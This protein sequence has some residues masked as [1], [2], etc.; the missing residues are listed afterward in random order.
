MT[1]I[2]T[3][4]V[5]RL[6][7]L[8]AARFLAFC[9]MVLVNFR[10]AAAVAPGTDWASV[11]IDSLE[12]R[13]AALFV[14][15][16]GIG[17]TLG[18]PTPGLMIRR[19]AFLFVIGVVNMTIF[20]ADILHFYALYFLVAVPFL[21]SGSRTLWIGAIGVVAASVLVH[22]VI[23]YDTGWDWD[24][25]IYTDLWTVPGFL[26]N[27]IFNGWHPVLP[28]AAFLLIGMALGR[29]DL[30]A[31][32]T[33]HRLILWGLAAALFALVPQFLTQDPDLQALLGTESIPPGPFYIMAGTGTACAII[34]L[35]LKLMPALDRLRVSPVLT[36]P[37][38]QTLT[39]YVAHILIGMGTLEELGLL[40]GSLTAPQITWI[41][42]G[43]AATTSIF[44][45]L[46]F[47]LFRR[48]PLEAIMRKVTG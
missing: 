1:K 4:G 28:W 15:L 27:A 38:K 31:R 11:M 32:C 44:A 3:K 9:G 46:W 19:A 5:P 29:S 45:L 40:D 35:T 12:G 48:G 14:V 30:G 23:E 10:I 20:D 21:S 25:L 22:G 34:G 41:G 18:K 8:D 33:Q 6:H 43:F 16:A 39:L 2:E 13:A 37:G 36:A 7:G 17:V 47:R 24:A 42:L 26:R